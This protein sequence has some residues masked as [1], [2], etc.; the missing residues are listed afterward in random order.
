MPVAHAPKPKRRGKPPVTSSES[1]AQRLRILSA[2][3]AAWL[4]FR[5]AEDLDEDQEH[6]RQRL[7]QHSPT[8]QTAYTLTQELIG[9]M[10]KPTPDVFDDWLIRAQ[11]TAIP[12]LQSFV[13]GLRRDYAAVK[14]A[15]SRSE[16]N[17][18]VEGQVNR[19]KFIKR[20]MYGRANFDLLRLR[21]LAT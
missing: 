14:A 4:L 20:S 3:Q 19:L 21:V 5:P 13:A 12:E 6:C 15:L 7:C 8:L 9:M 1:T 17:G 2:R 16:S 18:Q 11:A 10:R